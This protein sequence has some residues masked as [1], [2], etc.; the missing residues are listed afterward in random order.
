MLPISMI[1]RR[2]TPRHSFN[3]RFAAHHAT[4][5]LCVH[6]GNAANPFLSCGYF[7]TCGYPGVGGLRHSSAA[8][9]RG[10]CCGL[11]GALK[12][13]PAFA[14]PLSLIPSPFSELCASV[15]S[16]PNLSPFNFKLLALFTL[17]NEG[18][19]VEGST[20]N[21]FSPIP[22]R[23]CTYAKCSR[24]PFGM[25]TSKTKNLKLFRMNTYKKTG[26]GV[27]LAPGA[28]LAE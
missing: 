23:M 17:R 16:S 8:S 13:T 20:F 26:E 1:R 22:F 9:V 6:A 4:T 14:Q 24:N 11:G 2:S 7:I 21:C 25:S 19:V 3:S 15:L 27:S 28:G 10:D 12:P 18:S 5:S